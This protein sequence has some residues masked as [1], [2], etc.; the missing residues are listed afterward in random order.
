MIL[1]RSAARCAGGAF[2]GAAATSPRD[3][4]PAPIF[5]YCLRGVNTNRWTCLRKDDRG[6]CSA[7]VAAVRAAGAGFRV[8]GGAR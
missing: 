6:C 4:R 8:N 5:D 3:L 7:A 2:H 1:A